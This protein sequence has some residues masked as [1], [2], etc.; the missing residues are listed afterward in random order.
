MFVPKN[1]VQNQSGNKIFELRETWAFGRLSILFC[2]NCTLWLST[3][4]VRLVRNYAL[5]WKCNTGHGLTED[6]EVSRIFNSNLLAEIYLFFLFSFVLFSS[7]PLI[8][9]QNTVARA[10]VWLKKAFSSTQISCWTLLSLPWSSLDFT[11]VHN[12]ASLNKFRRIRKKRRASH[13]SSQISGVHMLNFW[14][15]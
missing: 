8:Q 2:I 3:F 4:E 10:F 9:S 1:N 14:I 11:P 6:V 15:W 12:N 7:F 13:A 5:H